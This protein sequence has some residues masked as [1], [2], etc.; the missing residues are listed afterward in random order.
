MSCTMSALVEAQRDGRLTPRDQA[1]ISRHVAGCA[2]CGELIADLDRLVEL[3]RRA[4]AVDALSPL[5]H[6]RRRLAL[7]RAVAIPARKRGTNKG[8]WGLALAGCV[9]LALAVVASFDGRVPPIEPSLTLPSLNVPRAV[10]ATVEPAPEA[11]F[12]RTSTLLAWGVR[13]DGVRLSDGTIELQIEHLSHGQQFVVV[14][15]DAELEVKGTRFVVHA[16]AGVL[17]HVVVAEGQVELRRKGLVTLLQTGDAWPPPDAASPRPDI[18]RGQPL[19]GS[20]PAAPHAPRASDA[21]TSRPAAGALPAATPPRAVPPAA[22]SPG[23]APP[24]ASPPTASPPVHETW[25]APDE[26]SA[27]FAAAVAELEAHDYEAAQRSLRQFTRDHP[28]DP[29]SEDAHFLAIVALQ[30]AGR[31]AAAAVAARH[32]L[33]RYPQ[34]ARRAEAL[35]IA[36]RGDIHVKDDRGSSE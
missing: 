25:P 32:Y 26:R 22:T 9:A 23:A 34:G 28:T 35:A 12:E 6:R 29:R 10:T 5:E 14:T 30:H 20:L 7:L 15:D 11:R 27:A 1:S 3:G 2:P 13:V 16:T 33:A 31:H 8:A 19:V 17:Q 4:H 24:T 36:N 18:S 21:R